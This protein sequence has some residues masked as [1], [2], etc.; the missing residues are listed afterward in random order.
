MSDETSGGKPAAAAPVPHD[1]AEEPRGEALRVELPRDG[2]V[3]VP[4]SELSFTTSRSSGPGGQNVNKVETRVTVSFPVAAS[5]SLDERQRALVLE[6]LARRISREGVLQVSAQR[7]RSQAQNRADALERLAGLLRDALSEDKPR[8]ATR[9][10]AAGRRR[11]LAAK[12]QRAG[13]KRLRSQP[14]ED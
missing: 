12:R 6:R 5:P 1:A 4:L 2:A 11:R 8:R 9:P 14:P 13:V 10:T 7:H 3:V